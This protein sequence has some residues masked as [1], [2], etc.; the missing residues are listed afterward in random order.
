VIIRSGIVLG[1][2]GGLIKQIYLP[3]YLGL[4][5]PIGTGKQYM[6]WIHIDDL[7][8][9]FLF[10]LQVDKVKGILNGVAPQVK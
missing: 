7:V 2:N 6:P 9:M 4:G 3:F 5:G 8:N 10:A 1:K